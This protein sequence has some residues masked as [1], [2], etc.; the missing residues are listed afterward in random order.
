MVKFQCNYSILEYFFSFFLKNHQKSQLATRGAIDDWP[1][2][3]NQNLPHIPNIHPHFVTKCQNG[4]VVDVG[5]VADHVAIVEHL[6][7][8]ALRYGAGKEHWAHVRAF[9]GQGRGRALAARNRG[10]TPRFPRL[11]GRAQGTGG[12]PGPT[13]FDP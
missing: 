8:L 11:E 10:V 12:P 3:L 7:G 9:P 1:E 5:E 6:D 13:G 4:D 2:I